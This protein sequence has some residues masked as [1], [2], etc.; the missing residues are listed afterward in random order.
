MTTFGDMA[1]HMGGV[2]V[3][4][5]MQ[6]VFGRHWFVDA[7]IGSDGNSGRRPDRPFLTMGKAIGI[8][9]SGDVIYF[10]GKVREHVTAPIGLSDVTIV[11]AT[12]KPRHADDHTEADGIRGSTGAT[13][14]AP[15]SP[16]A[17]TPNLTVRGQGWRFVNFLMASST[18]SSPAVKLDRNQ[19]SG[20][21][22]IDGGHAEFHK[23]RF[24]A[25]PIGIQVATTGFIGV[26]NS[27]FRGCTTSGI[28][29]TT[30]GG[31]SNGFWDIRGNRFMDNGTHILVPLLQSTVWGNISGKFT[32]KGFDFT[33]GSTNSV[34]GNWLSGDYDA[35]YVA[36]TSDD[37]AGNYSMDVTSAEVESNGLTILAPAA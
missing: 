12:N 29:S 15:A 14:M 1:F 27:Y 20:N 13:W 25:C 30:G 23:M 3:G 9:D 31:G 32:T 5:P 6:A 18:T 10:R 28:G 7:K 8:A 33:N 19:L 4:A 37:W 24:D 17:L 11:G 22:E 34:H 2:P 26:Y 21:D 35:G 36:G 16:T